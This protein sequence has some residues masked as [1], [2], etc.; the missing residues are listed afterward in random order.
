MKF[1]KTGSLIRRHNIL[2]VFVNIHFIALS[3]INFICVLSYHC[4]NFKALST[5]GKLTAN[6]FHFV[7]FI[8]QKLSVFSETP[9]EN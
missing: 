4:G 9:T 3:L 6:A 2:P 7:L 5:E 8:E 1:H